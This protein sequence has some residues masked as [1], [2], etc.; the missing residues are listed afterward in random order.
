MNIEVE[1][2]RE[3]IDVEIETTNSESLTLKQDI[4]PFVE[5]ELIEKDE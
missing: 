5:Y 4:D 2:V 1:D 3:F